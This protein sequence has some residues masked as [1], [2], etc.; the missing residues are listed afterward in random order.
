MYTLCTSKCVQLPARADAPSPAA[1][2]ASSGIASAKMQRIV[3]E[4]TQRSEE[5]FKPAESLAHWHLPLGPWG[6]GPG[7]GEPESESGPHS[8]SYLEEPRTAGAF[9]G[10]CYGDAQSPEFAGIKLTVLF[11][12][13]LNITQNST[14]LYP[15]YYYIA[16]YST[17]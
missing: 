2:A 17:T 14:I 5:D 3:L 11:V 1:A 9:G 15:I 12:I 7:A 16:K 10:H 4:Q 13:L 6:P 8:G